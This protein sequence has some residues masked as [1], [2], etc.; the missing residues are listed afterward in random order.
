MG[1]LLAN[2]FSFAWPSLAENFGSSM[3]IPGM[4]NAIEGIRTALVTGKFR[5]LF[6]LLFG[7]GMY[8]QYSKLSAAG[9]WPGLYVKRTLFLALI[10]IA[11]GVLIW[12]G[13]ILFMYSLAAFIAMFLVKLE[14]R[15]LIITSVVLGSLT[16]LCGGAGLIGSIYAGEPSGADLGPGM[17]IFSIFSA[18]NELATYQSGSYLTQ[19]QHRGAAFGFMSTLIPIILPEL[20]CLFLVGIVIC[21]RGVLAKP[22][23]HPDL[24]RTLLWVGGAG[25]LFNLLVGTL[26]FTM[27][28]TKLDSVVEF[29]LNIPLAIGYAIVG[30]I[31]VEKFANSGWVKMFSTVGKMGLTCYLLT[32]LIC[33][34]FFYGWG[35]GQF[36]KF[37]YIQMLLFVPVVWAILVVTAHLWLSRFPQ[38]PVEWLWRR[39]VLGRPQAMTQ[40]NVGLP[41]VIRSGDEL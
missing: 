39:A 14:D 12:Y 16:L 31:A 22:S 21:R 29:G 26:T 34:A 36:G 40:E 33:T 6:C 37:N 5:G 30:A 11:H 10:G 4:N 9:R 27:E 2:I 18:S 8:L 28:N 17:E 32:S 1:I 7:A 38:G 19:L 35:G 23:A 15:V 20:L 13:D 25:L 24:T 41:P 3:E